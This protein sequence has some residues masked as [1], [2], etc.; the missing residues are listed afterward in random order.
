M[1][2]HTND[3]CNIETTFIQ[4]THTTIVLHSRSKSGKIMKAY[5]AFTWK[6]WPATL[7]DAFCEFCAVHSARFLCRG[8]WW[9]LWNFSCHTNIQG[10][11][12][13]RVKTNH[14]SRY[15]SSEL[16]HQYSGLQYLLYTKL[17]ALSSEI[18]FVDTTNTKH[19][20]QCKASSLEQDVIITTFPTKIYLLLGTTPPCCTAKSWHDLFAVCIG[21]RKESITTMSHG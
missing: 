18:N 20:Y 12:T 15:C 14:F 6:K 17:S 3:L 19:L 9:N 2:E 13:Y 1:R 4:W 16:H 21:T 7:S 8:T 5:E 11:L 10:L